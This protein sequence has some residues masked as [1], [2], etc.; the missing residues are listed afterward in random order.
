M[1]IHIKH[2]SNVLGIYLTTTKNFLILGSYIEKKRRI[3]PCA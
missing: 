2:F 1:V 3:Y